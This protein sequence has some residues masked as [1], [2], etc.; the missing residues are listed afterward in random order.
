[1]FKALTPVAAILIAIGL[2]VTYV[3][4]SF[5]AIQAMER[6]ATEYE[7]ALKQA[8]TL[9]ARIDEKLERKRSFDQVGLVRLSQLLPTEIS[10]VDTILTLDGM[11][12]DHGMSLG[13]IEITEAEGEAAG[14]RPDDDINAAAID[15][16]LDPAGTAAFASAKGGVTYTDFGFSVEGTY[17]QLKDF[18]ADVERSLT[19]FEIM[20]LSFDE[21]E[22]DQTKF[23]FILRTYAHTATE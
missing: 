17:E 12:R 21:S 5:V 3:Q 20:S 22:G 13:D 6:E 23:V 15:P 19:L 9:Q 2:A 8:N 10:E 14:V 11:A 16:D 1:M 18:V 4:P 7:N